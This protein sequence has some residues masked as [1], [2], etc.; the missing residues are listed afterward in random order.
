[1][2]DSQDDRAPGSAHDTGLVHA[3]NDSLGSLDATLSAVRRG[4]GEDSEEG[5]EVSVSPMG[6]DSG[7]A[8]LNRAET[9]APPDSDPGW[10]LMWSTTGSGTLTR[11]SYT[12]TTSYG[13]WYRIQI[14]GGAWIHWQSNA[15]ST[16][17]YLQPN[18]MNTA[19][20]NTPSTDGF[21]AG[22]ITTTPTDANLAY[23]SSVR[24][25]GT[26]NRNPSTTTSYTAVTSSGPSPAPVSGTVHLATSATY[27]PADTDG[28]WT[29]IW[30]ASGSGTLT[31]F[32]YTGTTSYGQWYRLRVDGGA[33]IHW[34][35]NAW[36][37]TYY[38]L[39]NP[40]DTP[41]FNT[42]GTEGFTAGSIT[43]T[44]LNA[45]VAFASSVLVQGTTNRPGG[46]DVSCSVSHSGSSP[47]PAN[48]APTA[49]FQTYFDS[50]LLVRV[51]AGCSGDPDGDP[52]AYSWVWGDG[53][54]ATG[55]PTKTK[56]YACPGGTFTIRLT[57]NDG[58]GGS[59]TSSESIHT[60]DT[61][62]V[63]QDGLVLC[64]E[65]AQGTSD[66][67]P[68]HDFDGLNDYLE[69][70][71]YPMHDRNAIFCRDGGSPCEYPSPTVRDIYVWQDVMD[72][73][74]ESGRCLIA[75]TDEQ[76]TIAKNLFQGKGFRL[77]I[78]VG[79]KVPY[80]KPF[81]TESQWKSYYNTNMPMVKRGVFHYALIADSMQSSCG[82]LP[83][84]DRTVGMGSAPGFMF[85]L[86][87]GC[88]MNVYF[89]WEV[90]AMQR[91]SFIH[92]LGHNLIGTIEPSQ[93][94]GLDDNGRSDVYHHNQ[95]DYIM[96]YRVE[97]QQN[98]Y[99]PRRW[100][101]NLGPSND[102]GAG[103]RETNAQHWAANG[104]F[105]GDRDPWHH[106]HGDEATL[107][108]PASYGAWLR[109]LGYGETERLRARHH[110]AYA[111]IQSGHAR[112]TK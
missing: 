76:A 60:A 45:N 49:C 37:T 11:F 13:Q 25:E 78:F 5:E 73:C 106:L 95:Q 24:V 40:T 2:S 69:S 74:F 19:P 23:T 10:S 110:D 12:G 3:T 22:S 96:W 107:D 109:L 38:L 35:S 57:V 94:R 14:D 4:S 61:R 102:I 86:F 29:T 101:Y 97:S 62:D 99:G 16:T 50:I 58:R 66:G 91:R 71:W 80:Q 6:T 104:P 52:I 83:W 68:D 46:A 89:P 41:P 33:W 67:N 43:T 85:V 27:T 48:R 31:Q 87:H 17:Y 39:P 20:Y 56:T 111:E 30:S 7:S 42:G 51:E 28:A 103:L 77:H 34:Q 90:D 98:D 75:L 26:T 47:P 70:Q 82:V 9:V 8:T 88:M 15:G 21:T 65:A 18:P 53:T 36:S 92:E 84:E 112:E 44:Q 72:K 79:Y 32:A 100:S 93:D 63:D 1:V 81:N 108:D 54:T 64:R 59:A 105:L 55:G